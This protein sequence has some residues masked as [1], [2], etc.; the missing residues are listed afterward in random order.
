MP[1]PASDS[2]RTKPP[3]R[4]LACLTTESVRTGV[5]FVVPP[6]V[7][8]ALGSLSLVF[9]QYRAGHVQ[10][11]GNWWPSFWY[12]RFLVGSY[13]LTPYRVVK[14]G[15]ESMQPPEIL[16]LTACLLFWWLYVRLSGR[17]IR[18]P[19]ALI[20]AFSGW[21]IVL[22][23]DTLSASALAMLGF[24]IALGFTPLVLAW[25]GRSRSVRNREKVIPPFLYIPEARC[26]TRRKP[27][28]GGQPESL[29]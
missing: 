17:G 14:I 21:C 5:A 11:H 25:S 26:A 13:Q 7:G 1:V 10:I 22:P 3:R 16:A 6:A 12:S 15:L 27:R 18:L 4:A 20:A 23:I 28:T 19:A 9:D 2:Q 29:D 8:V 24:T